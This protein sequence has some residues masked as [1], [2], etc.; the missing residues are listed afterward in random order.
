MTDSTHLV[1]PDGRDPALDHPN[2]L[3][4]PAFHVE[5]R[6]EVEPRT[7]DG[8]DLRQLASNVDDDDVAHFLRIT[9]DPGE[10]DL[11]GG[12]E[13]EWPCEGRVGVEVMP[14]PQAD[15]EQ[16][17]LQAI[18]VAAAREALGLPPL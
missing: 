14:I 13:K 12:C 5:D 8:S 3:H 2:E 15:P 10:P 1:Y 7:R 9:P 6:S 17:H 16:E 4:P 11:C 18:A